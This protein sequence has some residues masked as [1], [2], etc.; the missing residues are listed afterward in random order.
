MPTV[1]L[2]HSPYL[3][4][5]SLR[6]LADTL[7]AGGV[8]S[9]LV[10][11]RVTVSAAPVHQR[12]IGAFADAM[13]EVELTEPAVLVG[14]S[15]AGPLLPAFAAELDEMVAGLVYVDAELPTP[16][17]S[18][19]QLQ[20]ARFAALRASARE[21]QLPRWSDWFTPNPFAELD[22]ALRA[23][24]TEEEP[25]VA[26]EFLKEQRPSAEWDGPSGYLLLTETYAEHAAAARESGWPVRE[27]ASNHLAPATD[28]APVAAALT[29]LLEML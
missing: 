17:Q 2:V 27:L 24:M 7:A 9:C 29:E 21:G 8:E 4:P 25:E 20:P 18:F 12:L 26:V 19:R 22:E 3:G 11:L 5:A 23:E 28:P 6:P 14:H 16:G 13:D 10:D 1:V 15:G